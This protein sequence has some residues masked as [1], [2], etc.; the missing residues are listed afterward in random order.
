MLKKELILKKVP[1]G[2]EIC[3]I[4][5]LKLVDKVVNTKVGPQIEKYIPNIKE[6]F[7]HL[8]KDELIKHFVSTEFNRFLAFYK[9]AEN[10]NIDP[11]NK[12]NKRRENKK[13]DSKSK[14]ISRGSSGSNHA[15]EGYTR[16]F[17][18]LGKQKGMQAQNL[19]GMINEFTKKRNI[20]CLLYTSPSPRD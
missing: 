11:N 14:R 4:Q 1:S 6:K 15:E 3:E 7:S 19:I 9:N 12:S 2:E 17:I 13:N 20:P 10:L 18:N 8:D 16:F 5:L